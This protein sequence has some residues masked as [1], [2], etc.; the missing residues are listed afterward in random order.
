MSDP[1]SARTELR[2]DE[3]HGH[4]ASGCPSTGTAELPDEA[5]PTLSW[6]LELH[7]AEAERART[8][9]LARTLQLTLKTSALLDQLADAEIRGA[10]MRTELERMFRQD[11]FDAATD[12][13]SINPFHD[14][15]G[16]AQCTSRIT[17]AKDRLARFL[18]PVAYSAR[19]AE[20]ARMREAARRAPR[21]WRSWAFALIAVAIWIATR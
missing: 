5:G 20:A 7:A 13:A 15:V 8:N 4:V 2:W 11:V 9:D 16:F 1:A 21:S 19:Q 18:D 6:M 3:R 14:P 17:T 12:R 10:R